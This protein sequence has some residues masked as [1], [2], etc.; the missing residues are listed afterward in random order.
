[1]RPPIGRVGVIGLGRM[2]LPMAGHLLRAGFE[3]TGFDLDDGRRALLRAAGGAVAPSAADVGRRSDAVIVMVTDDAQVERAAMELLSGLP[4]GSVLL[5]T[6]TVKPSTCREIAARLRPRGVAVLDAPVALG[7][8]AAE[9]GR[10]TAYVGG[11]RR[12]LERCRPLLQAYCREV[13]HVGDEIGAGQVAKLANN[14]ILWAGVVAVHEALAFGQRLGVA[15]ARLREALRHGS[16]DGYVLRE[17]H[18]INLTWP[19]KDIEQA[20]EA[21]EAIGHPLPLAEQVGRLIRGLT[22]DELRRLCSHGEEGAR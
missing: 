17:L 14:L 11:D 7:Q 4:D 16:A 8:R 18:L 6:A 15:P 13:I 21:A 2:G 12:V 10:L 19:H 3:V 22:K 5:I 20:L 9:E 1:M